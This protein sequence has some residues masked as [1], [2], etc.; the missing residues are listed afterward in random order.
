MRKECLALG[1]YQNFTTA[2]AVLKKLQKSGFRRSASIHHAHDDRIFISTYNLLSLLV[3]TIA[4]L[5]FFASLFLFWTGFSGLALLSAVVMVSVAFLG[6]WALAVWFTRI[7]NAVLNKFKTR[8]IRDETLVIVQL[9]SPDVRRVLAILREVES[10]HPTSFLLRSDIFSQQHVEDLPKEPLTS[11]QLHVRAIQLAESLRSIDHDM[12]TSNHNLL[13]RLHCCEEVL[14]TIRHD[15]AEAEQ[16]EQTITLSA[17][18]LLDNTHAIQGSIEE[19]Q[20]NLPNK[21]YKELPKIAEGPLVGLPRIYAIAKDMISCNACKLTREN[22]VAFLSAYQTIDPLTIGELWA[23]PLMLR[24]GLVEWVQYL[25][26]HI[27][28]RLCEGELASFWGNR[29]LNVAKREPDRIETFLKMLSQE[30]PN[31]SPHFAEELLDHLFDEEL[32]LP[33]V[34]KWLEEKFGENISE[35][36]H[37]EQIG[38]T[39]EQIAI[40]N[41]IVSL[42]NLSQLSWREIFSVVSPVD[43]IFNTDPAE[44]Y[45]KMDFTTQD[46]YRHSVEVVA[47]GSKK[48]EREIAWETLQLAYKGQDEVTRHIGYYLIDAGRPVLEKFVGYRPSFFQALRR[49]LNA[50]PAQIYLGSIGLLTVGIEAL[51]FSL[52]LAWEVHLGYAVFFAFLAL[53]P[54]SEISVQLVNLVLTRI[55]SP[56]ILPKMSYQKGIPENSKTLVV[57]PMMLTTPE[58]VQDKINRLEIHYLANP[59]PALRFALFSDYVDTLQPDE[60]VN[61]SLLQVA[62]DGIEALKNKYGEGIFF[63]FHRKPVWSESEGAWIGF[64]RK[65]G[66][67]ECLNR[68][69]LG[70]GTEEDI[71]YVGKREALGDIRYVITLDAD[72]RLPKDKARQLVETLSHPLNVPR[73]SESGN[74]ERGYTII[75]PRVSTDLP[76]SMASLFTKIFSDVMG[77]DPYTQVISDIYQDLVLEGTYHGKGIYDLRAFDRILTG[78]FPKET[79]LSHD[80]LEGAYVRVGFASDISLFDSF[81]EDYLTWSK[82]LHRW[83][84][85]DWQ[86]VGW[87]FPYVR[88][89]E[90]KKVRNPLSLINRW[91]IFDNLRRACMPVA[92]LSLL[93]VTWIL[94]QAAFLWTG[95]ATLVLFMPAISMFVCCYIIHLDSLVKNWRQ[96]AGSFLR[97][98]ISIVILPHQAILSLDALFRVLY[99]R[100]VSH[101]HLLEWMSF[102]RSS[103]TAHKRFILELGV[104]TLFALLVF[105]CVVYLQPEYAWLAFPYV[106]L[107]AVAP[108]VVYVLDRPIVKGVP[109]LSESDRLFLREVAR[110]TWRYFD[111][112]V[113]PQSNWLPPD[114]YQAALGIEIAQRTSPTNIGLWMLS[115]VSAYDL[116]YITCDDVIDRVLSTFHTLNKL[117]RYE[118]HLLNWYDIQT[119]LPLYPR[120]VS[121]VDSGNLIGSLWALEQGVY[122]MLFAPI[123][124]TSSLNGIRDTLHLAIQENSEKSLKKRLEDLEAI[125]DRK[126]LDIAGVIKVIRA[127]LNHVQ[128]MLN[129]GEGQKNYWFKQLEEELH[130]WDAMISRYFSWVEILGDIPR[131]DVAM[132]GEDVLVWRDQILATFPSLETLAKGILSVSVEPRAEFSE[133]LNNRLIQLK[134]A[135]QTA[136]WLAG[137]RMGLAQEL[138]QESRQLSENTDMTFLYN[139][140][141]KLFSIGYQVDAR[142]L[143]SSYY[144][145]LA[146]EARIASLVAIAKGEVPVEHWWALGR[147]YAIVSGRLVLRSWGG[148]MFEYLMPLLLNKSYPDSL[149]GEACEAAVACQIDYGKKRGI[150]WGISESAFS[151]ID[152]RKTYQYMSFGVPGMGFKRFLEEDL[153]VSPYSSALALSVNPLE[154]IKNLRVLAGKA[155]RLLSDYGYY[156]SIDFSRQQGP[157]GE[158]GV[159]IYAYMAHHQGM[160]LISVND[161]LNNQVMPRRFHSDP[162]IAGVES[163]LYENI[164]M[165][166]AIAK[167]YRKEIPVPRLIPFPTVPIMGLVDTPHT[168]TPKINLLSNSQYSIMVTNAGGGY[169][170]WKDIDITRWRADTTCDSL[171]SYCYIKDVESGALWSNAYHPTLTKGHHYSVKFKTDKTE[172]KRVDDQIETLTE[173]VV[174]P[175]DNAEIR[176]MTLANL[177]DRRRVLEL[178]SYSELALAP[179]LTDRS[180][181]AF[182]KLF[183]QTEVLEEFSGLLAFRRLRS[184]DDSPIW[185]AHVLASSQPLESFEYET[186]R[187]RFIGRGKDLKHPA[188]VDEKLSKTQGTVLDPVFSLRRRIVLEPG[189]RVK[190]AFITCVADNR[191]SAVELVKKYQDLEA[192]HRA[193]DMAWTHAQ[194]E[195]RYLRIQQEEAQLFQKLASRVLYPHSQLRPSNDRLC[196]NK[197]GQSRLWAYGISGDLPI[198]VVTIAD[199]HEIDLVRQVLTAHAFW[200]LRGLKTDLIILNEEATGYQQPLFQ[201]LQRIIQA[202][203]HYDDTE[204]PGGIFLRNS[205]QI[206]EED[207][208]LIL[209]SAR[210]LL[211]AARGFLRQQ[212]VSPMRART[213]PSR[214][215]LNKNKRDEPSKP[216]PFMELSHFNG[217]GGFT[218]DGREYIIYLGPNEH[219]PAP[220]VNVIA[221]PQFG[222]LVSETG[223]GSTW[224]GNSQ[225]NRLTA[226]SNDPLVNPISDAIY[227][228]DDEIGTFW[229][230]TPGPIRELDA[231]RVRHGQGYSR[232]EHN[233]HGIEQDL[234]IFVPV[235]DQGGLPVRVQKLRLKNASSRHRKLS[236]MSYSDLVLG[237]DKEDTQMHVITDWDTE[238]QSLFSYNRYNLDFCDHLAFSCSIPAAATYT[239]DRTEFLGRNGCMSSPAALKR[240]SLS[241][242]TGAALDPCCALQ[243]VVDLE[244]GEE[245]EVIFVLGYAKD[246][247]AARNLVLKCREAGYLDQAYATTQG[248]WD[249]ILET[250][251]I[252][253]PELAI[254]HS[255]NRWLLYQNLSCR[256]WGRTAFYQSSGAYGF[257]DQLQD[258]MAL[259]Y[260]A[261]HIT[262]EQILLAASRQFIEGDVQHWWHPPSGAGVRT[263]IT[264][265]LLWLPYVTAHYVKVTR[266]FSILEEQIPFLK[267]ELLKEGEHEAY[268]VPE[269]SSEVGSLLEHCRRAIRKGVTSGPHGLPLMGGGDWNDGMNRVG[270]EGRGESVWLAW[271]LIEVMNRFA[272]LLIESGQPGGGGGE[273]LRVEAKRLAEIVEAKAWDGNW[274]RR[275]YFDDGKPLGSKDSPEAIIDSLAQSWA[276]ISGAG[277]PERVA[278]ALKSLEEHLVKQDDRLVLLL[279]PPFDKSNLDP[280]YI[281][282]YPPGVRENGGQYTH[283]SL[284]VPMAFAR[285]GEGD[286]AVHLLWMMHPMSHAA[287]L[288]EAW[289][290]KVEPYALAADIYALP[291][292]VGRGGWTWYTGSAG[293]MYRIWLEEIIGF[294]VRGTVLTLRPVLPKGWDR[295]K[296]DYR[297]LRSTYEIVIENPEHK[298]CG[299][300]RVELDGVHLASGEVVLVDDGGHH[301]VRV[302]IT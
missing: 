83:I 19:V 193:I 279:T 49:W 249:K 29:L 53:L 194:L 26:I 286:K 96:A 20:R 154:A 265:D 44:A 145:L 258:V 81:P 50:H 106:L 127:A 260:T 269:I 165:N 78:R 163:L 263:R 123:L 138:I 250:V 149:L 291:G 215:V 274:Y 298:G 300:V 85:G 282:G 3:R 125:L 47:R 238:S 240:T 296:V 177:S 191:D 54:V 229:T 302:V 6:I 281:K 129:S 109:G 197:L 133:S 174:S 183:I 117:E 116:K 39:V 253:I 267:G 218:A 67:L 245:K 206:P 126:P 51:V 69:L 80:L 219:T 301:A 84:R 287:N 178:T 195:L 239:A 137:E 268:F 33:L 87:L 24:L 34:R 130:S 273:G 30:Q 89:G 171:G 122:E 153:V 175:E 270:I 221:N 55:L 70:K 288:E 220:W 237:K 79:L 224:Y 45:A 150:P 225:S 31:P 255:L 131:T 209:S 200:R 252:E 10:G 93:V 13:E 151:A 136:Q 284:W 104:S 56:Y 182:N 189:E 32:A 144:D 98:L 11:D 207:L 64:E 181:P 185:A 71:L 107:W 118:G 242:V 155:Y 292:Q 216:L 285:K 236:V 12:H 241:G 246:A 27:D 201:Q 162:R 124:S 21:Y 235:D 198:V 272:D 65:R 37:R 57:I 141:R 275:A 190:V 247:D 168:I 164:P 283:G 214:L 254:K 227:I 108:G 91:K 86:I 276:V 100:L 295:V 280:G 160:S 248:W 94:S 2:Q 14:R 261:P 120:Y 299:S 111:D 7:D 257:R 35:V 40:S 15:V 63:L 143:D 202:H 228:R 172:I 128:D 211:I 222:T 121:T 77:I 166:P 156:E 266:D 101:R 82:R 251:K 167:G 25:A 90:G 95:L 61:R 76:D 140:E 186:D 62:I 203:A 271:F 99:R 293:W 297:Y 188:A 36:V 113:G 22:I 204:K 161:V 278:L 213:Q 110:R 103:K 112:F 139:T 23:M 170:R 97:A 142:K 187:A 135:C 102:N 234:L 205:D 8:V 169:S 68:Y 232:F 59:D 290:Y 244:P 148:T 58:V 88:D 243:V 16:V 176:L 294:C 17:E 230:P 146:S 212:L 158:R 262:R 159:I 157:H 74:I 1:Y 231:Y 179:H 233:S 66:K 48:S 73:L 264:D 92:I 105:G 199:L 114:N 38:K 52:S 210:V 43:A 9:K 60:E 147:A 289:K 152:V 42:I 115:V 256:I 75:Q 72:T 4:V 223:L 184:P 173:M 277:K 132:L 180:H 192:S 259:V 5:A 28:R 226:W 208:T 119:L 134:G 196:R 217:L 46:A 18:W 41:V